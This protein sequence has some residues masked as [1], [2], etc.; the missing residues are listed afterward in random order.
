MNNSRKVRKP[1]ARNHK[2][3]NHVVFNKD[4]NYSTP[5]FILNFEQVLVFMTQEYYIHTFEDLKK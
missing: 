3:V 2:A 1:R 5:S 4:K